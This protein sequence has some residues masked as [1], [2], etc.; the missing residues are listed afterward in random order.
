MVLGVGEPG[1]CHDELP[2]TQTTDVHRDGRR[3]IASQVLIVR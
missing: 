1:K 2:L 3:W